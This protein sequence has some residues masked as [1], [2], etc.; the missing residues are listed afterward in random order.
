MS[1]TP[2][3]CER[4]KTVILT[5]AMV[6]SYP[7]KLL[8]TVPETSITTLAPFTGSTALSPVAIKSNYRPYNKCRNK[9]GDLDVH[10]VR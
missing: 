10:S 5:R 2:R 7:V 4:G 1:T 9:H 6:P 3:K 8:S